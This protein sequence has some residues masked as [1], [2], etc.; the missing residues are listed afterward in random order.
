MYEMKHNSLQQDQ[1]I[2]ARKTTMNKCICK[3]MTK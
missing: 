2:I 1:K 3:E